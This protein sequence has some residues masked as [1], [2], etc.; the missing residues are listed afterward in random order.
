MF[1]AFSDSGTAFANEDVI[2][3]EKGM[4]YVHIPVFQA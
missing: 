2:V 4:D 3:K 1:F